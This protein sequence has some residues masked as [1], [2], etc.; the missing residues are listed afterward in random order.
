VA[1]LD[2]I[3]EVK[4]LSGALPPLVGMRKRISGTRGE[5]LLGPLR[6][7]FEV[8][9]NELHYRAP[10][11]GFVD[12]IDVGENVGQGRATFNGKQFGRFEL[13]RAQMAK[14]EEKEERIAV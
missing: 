2:G 14:E 11:S 9:G 13:R 3:W 5:T 12:V 10:F 6:M 7:P 8:R 4:R 1:Q